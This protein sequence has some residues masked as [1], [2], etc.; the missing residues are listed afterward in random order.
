M[1]RGEIW[2]VNL[3]PTIG[4]EISK[5]RP[6][7]IFSRDT[8][9]RLPLKVIVPITE[10]KEP[11]SLIRWFVQLEPSAENGL[12]KLSAADTFQVRSVSRERLIRQLGNLSDIVMEEIANA[13]AI[14]LG[15]E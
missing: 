8:V 7:V 14:V 11:Y 10:W 12:S 5:T 3:E 9:G 4:A 1:R 2:L 15:M 13:L 6:A